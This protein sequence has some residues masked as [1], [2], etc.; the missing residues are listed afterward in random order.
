MLRPTRLVCLVWLSLGLIGC[1]GDGG[2]DDGGMGSDGSTP[3]GCAGEA[4]GTPCGS[5]LICVGEECVEEGCGDGFVGD[6]E[7]CDDGNM[8]AFDGCEPGTC[9]FTCT[10]A[11]ECDDGNVCNGAETC[12]SSNVCEAGAPSGDGTACTR[13][14][15]E[16]GVCRGPD[17]VAAGC[18][19]G[20]VDSGEACDD[21]NDVEGDGCDTDCTLSCME[22][23]DCAD[24]DVCNGGETCDLATNACVA[25]EA[26][27]CDDGDACTAND[28]DPT[29]GCENPLIDAD[30]DGH[31]PESLGACGDDCDDSD[32]ARY[33][34]A[35]ELCDGVDNDCNDI[36]DD[37]APT[38]YIYCDGDG[39]ASDTTGS[40][41]PNCDPPSSAPAGCSGGGWTSV[42]PVGGSSTDCND[43][44]ANVFPGQRT[45]FSTP[46]PGAPSATAYDYDCSGAHSREYGCLPRGAT[47]GPSC[48]DGYLEYDSSTNPNGCRF[49][50]LS[51]GCFV[52]ESPDCGETADYRDCGGSGGGFCFI[53]RL[54]DVRQACR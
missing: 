36:V 38:W 48:G 29:N 42:R 51:T 25:G 30:M 5:G 18:G 31:A 1:G 39:Y 21:G 43:A 17:C 11:A 52:I 27:D 23:L 35:E 32:P 22:D 49:L 44:N 54:T 28:C 7:V 4:D 8:T 47:C 15:G 3:A 12:G 41:G 24:A 26:L 13:P 45:Y 34:G 20:V 50:C 19:N 53:A 37:G 9:T 6:G 40:V 16:P 10:D 46:I 14:G 2:D 33:G